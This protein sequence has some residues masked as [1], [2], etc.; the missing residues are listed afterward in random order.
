M[1]V[2]TLWGTDLGAALGAGPPVPGFHGE[3]FIP[4]SQ[5]HA[6]ACTHALSTQVPPEGP[7]KLFARLLG[8][9]W[10]HRP[11]RTVNLCKVTALY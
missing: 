10:K 3:P 5:T 11:R 7:E 2:P 8:S 4:A 1:A 9:R 6:C